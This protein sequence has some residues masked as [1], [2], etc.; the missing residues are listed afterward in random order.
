MMA[1]NTLSQVLDCTL[2]ILTPVH[3]GSGE[4]WTKSLDVFI[5]DRKVHIVNSNKLFEEL[6]SLTA[7]GNQSG[8]DYYC[9]LIA[10][11]RKQK[12]EQFFRD[13]NIDLELLSDLSFDYP[14]HGEPQSEIR[15][16]IRNRN[17]TTI[18]PGSSIKG[19]IASAILGYRMQ[20]EQVRAER[21]IERRLLGQ[22]ER[23]MTRYIRPYDVEIHVATQLLN[24]DLFNLYRAGLDLESDFKDQQFPTLETFS[25]GGTGSF[26][27]AVDHGFLSLVIE[28]DQ[29]IPHPRTRDIIKKSNPIQFLFYIINQ[30]TYN[31]LAREIDFFEEYHQ[32]EGTD[33]M[34]NA[35]KVLQSKTLDNPNSCV[36]RMSYG[37]GFHGITGEINYRDHTDTGFWTRGR[38]RDKMKYKSRKFGVDTPYVPLGFVELI[39]PEDAERAKM[40]Q[41][42]PN[43]NIQKVGFDEKSA[44]V[45]K[46][47]LK[48]IPAA[49]KYS[50]IQAKKSA[51]IPAEI[52]V[53]KKPHSTV[54][55]LIENYP[56]EN[57][58]VQ[59]SGTKKVKLVVGQI[60][61]VTVNSSTKAGEIKTV[62][63]QS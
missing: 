31:H 25:E 5:T 56:F 2:K 20:M 14:P 9:S 3:A 16:L 30:H 24:L 49:I 29:R 10:S 34:I 35:L 48:S 33:E 61:K 40:W 53:I 17:N 50:E 43:K 45:E 22:F 38:D 21:G 23:G 4:V 28:K 62:K 41:P 13:E 7:R 51:L 54:K 57:T 15:Q 6:A 60:V 58:I 55:L 27:L 63:Y 39:L 18:L 47:L 12:I 46:P 36:L 8:L 42:F 37:S 32:A 52:L 11:G 59:M 1:T 26:R 44:T 19:A